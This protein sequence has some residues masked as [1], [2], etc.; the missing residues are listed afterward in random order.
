MVRRLSN[1]VHFGG[2]DTGGALSLLLLGVAVLVPALV[3]ILT[4]RKL[5]P[6]A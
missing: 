5:R 4:G 2:E 1:I 3:V 6:L